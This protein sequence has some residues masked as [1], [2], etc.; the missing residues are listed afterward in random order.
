MVVPREVGVRPTRLSEQI[1]PPSTAR[2]SQFDDSSDG[3]VRE[4]LAQAG[5][6]AD[7]SDRHVRAVTQAHKFDGNFSASLRQ[8]L[9]L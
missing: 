5:R 8:I 2:T 3:Y 7:W 4:L 1:V 6:S 9:P